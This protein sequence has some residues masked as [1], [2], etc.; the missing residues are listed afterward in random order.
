[1]NIDIFW[2]GSSNNKLSCCFKNRIEDPVGTE[3]EN[4]SVVGLRKQ[5][6]NSFTDIIML[7]SKN[8]L[9]SGL[10]Y[11]EAFSQKFYMG[12]NHPFM[13]RLTQI[14]AARVISVLQ[15]TSDKI[16]TL[17]DLHLESITP[18]IPPDIVP[19]E[20]L[21]ELLK[22]KQLDDNLTEL[23]ENSKEFKQ[24]GH[25]QKVKD[26]KSEIREAEEKI[27]ESAIRLERTLHQYPD[28]M[29]KLLSPDHRSESAKQFI[30]IF[31]LLVDLSK[32][33]LETTVEEANEKS[34]RMEVLRDR[35]SKFAQDKD[36]LQKEKE[37]E[38]KIHGKEL[39][40]LKDNEYRLTITLTKIKAEN[41]TFEAK[42]QSDLATMTEALNQQHKQRMEELRAENERLQEE[43][44]TVMQENRAAEK[45]VRKTK[46][47]T[48]QDVENRISN[49][50]SQMLEKRNQYIRAGEKL[51]NERKQI[52][53]LQEKIAE[54]DRRAKIDEF[55][56]QLDEKIEQ[57][58]AAAKLKRHRQIALIQALY[59][60]RQAI[61]IGDAL[62][63]AAA[64][65]K[66]KS[67]KKK[68]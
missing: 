22:H 49:Y 44:K 29:N 20:L 26:N 64:R 39:Q 67:S 31:K 10:C 4:G 57:E 50:D 36:A 1:M 43:L 30:E 51:E 24:P 5:I 35:E 59:R 46:Q 58:K 60:R 61:K 62:R 47:Q 7:V 8:S 32:V 21:S 28:A 48:S 55:Q 3:S 68:K 40:A 18:D 38:E 34:K 41:K 56:A 9:V 66:K 13:N 16:K 11:I 14:E 23:I 25:L 6:E 54:L 42:C 33:R 53:E 37:E 65:K 63:R 45:E 15:T 27:K 19:E 2:R 12:Y 17:L 52:T